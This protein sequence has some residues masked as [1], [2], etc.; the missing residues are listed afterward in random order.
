[1]LYLTL[2]TS[3]KLQQWNLQGRIK[4]LKYQVEEEEDLRVSVMILERN[5][6]LIPEDQL[7]EDL[8]AIN[9]ISNRCNNSKQCLGMFSC[10]H[11]WVKINYCALMLMQL[12]A[13]LSCMISTRNLRAKTV[14]S[15]T[16]SLKSTLWTSQCSL[17]SV[18]R[19]NYLMLNVMPVLSWRARWSLHLIRRT[20][21]W[22]RWL[23][24]WVHWR[25]K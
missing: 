13:K 12:M 5:S 14:W 11:Q 18:V 20:F 24:S 7:E 17:C 25:R 16:S 21:L 10:H 8:E 1:M 19:S 23:Q 15:I 4:V 2:M 6:R 3:N 9:K 22:A